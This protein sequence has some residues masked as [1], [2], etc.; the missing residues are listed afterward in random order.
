MS[1]G[2]L[3]QDTLNSRS[4]ADKG[5]ANRDGKNS[6]SQSDESSFDANGYNVSSEGTPRKEVIEEKEPDPAERE[7]RSLLNT[8]LHSSYSQLPTSNPDD[9]QEEVKE[10]RVSKKLSELTTK[11]VVFLVLIVI[12][13]IPLLQVDLYFE[14][15]SSFEY[16]V[17]ALTITGISQA[18]FSALVDA[19]E[20]YHRD[21]TDYPVIELRW[22]FAGETVHHVFEDANSLRSHNKAKYYLDGGEVIFNKS[23]EVRF[24]ACLSLGMTI[25]ICMLLLV[26]ALMISKDA[27]ELVLRPLEVIMHKIN[28]M[29]QDPFQVLKF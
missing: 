16:S 24:Q 27:Q 3:K 6:I 15:L 13:V 28:Q 18:E 22:T 5:A 20:R 4:S 11:R 1:M 10:S 14:Q 21:E 25:F 9:G 29:A 7:R 12:L 8:S 19:I 26:G 17:A 2:T 23:A